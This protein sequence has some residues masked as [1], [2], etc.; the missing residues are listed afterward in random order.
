MANIKSAKKRARQTKKRELQNL[1]RRRAAK[2]ASVAVK[3]AVSEKKTPEELKKIVA[4][5]SRALDKA[6]KNSR[7]IHHNKAARIKSRL[8][9]LVSKAES[10][11]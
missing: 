7:A 9:K 2:N 3:K 8:A 10:T 1:R 4:L 11:K 6:A 5:A